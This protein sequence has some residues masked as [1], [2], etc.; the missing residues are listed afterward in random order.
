MSPADPE[1]VETRKREI[2]TFERKASAMTG[3]T[4]KNTLFQNRNRNG[5]AAMLNHTTE[6]LEAPPPPRHRT[7]VPENLL[8]NGEPVSVPAAVPAG[9]V[10]LLDIIMRA[11]SDP[12]F[13]VAKF[14]RLVQIQREEQDRADA[15]ADREA[16]LTAEAAFNAAMSAVQRKMTSVRAT[17]ENPQTRSVYA[18]YAA[19]DRML[20]PIYSE[21]DFALTYGEEDSPKPDHV[22]VY[23]LV[24]HSPP[25]T[26]RSHTR[27]YHTD[28]PADGKGARGGDVMSKTHATKSAFTYSQGALVRLIFNIAVSKDDD[29]NAAGTKPAAETP[30]VPGTISQAQADEIRA[31]LDQRRVSHRA[32]LQFIRLPR[33]ED[34]GSEHFERAITKIKSF[35]GQS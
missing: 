1:F 15:R 35:G 21:A 28:M 16:E 27:K 34:I 12:S 32:F 8:I 5:A 18:D 24:T 29:G 30:K 14:E 2:E 9:P 31:L 7:R 11:G 10:S 26:K 33:I 19:L 3:R 25:E 4:P 6:T 20:R 22:R 17:V 13:D 23:C